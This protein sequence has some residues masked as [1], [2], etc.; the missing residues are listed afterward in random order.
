MKF[1]LRFLLT[2]FFLQIGFSAA[3]AGPIDVSFGDTQKTWS[4]WGNGSP[5]DASDVIGEPDFRGGTATFNSGKL[6][7]L[8]FTVLTPNAPTNW[9]ASIQP[10]DLFI[11]VGS[12]SN[13]NYVVDLT[14]SDTWTIG[15][16]NPGKA[17]GAGSYNIY[18]VNI[19]IELD[20]AQY[21]LS[22]KD[23]TTIVNGPDWKG[24]L[25]RDDHPIAW[26]GS[27]PSAPLGTVTFSGWDSS[28]SFNFAGLTG[29][30]LDAGSTIT[31]GWTVTCANDV[32]YETINTPVP[33]PSTFVFFGS[34]LV[35]L[36]A[37]IRRG[38]KETSTPQAY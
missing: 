25:I 29:G 33:E 28:P 14:T 36:A 18:S 8:A 24:F 17:V 38:R 22:G 5:D 23:D 35:G 6:T 32:L 16:K 27:L 11:R 37:Y 10:G 1:V 31:I 34:G 3:I 2:L 15:G 30:G 19:P 21:T 20:T 7:G 9:G 13:W 26:G 4:N 12:G